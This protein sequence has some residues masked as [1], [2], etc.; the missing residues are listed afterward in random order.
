MTKRQEMLEGIVMD[1]Y[2]DMFKQATPS[3]DFDLLI[4]TGEAKRDNFFDKYFLSEEVQISIIEKHC[5]K[6]KLTKR[7]RHLIEKEIWLG[8]SPT[9]N[10]K[11][12]N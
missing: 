12:I 4:K 5:K 8:C 6:Y 2:R 3:A 9:A 10:P 1:I 11:V 7:E